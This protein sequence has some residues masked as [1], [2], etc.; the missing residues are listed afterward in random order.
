M[1]GTL[2][3]I[4]VVNDK[5][6]LSIYHIYEYYIQVTKKLPEYSVIKIVPIANMREFSTYLGLDFLD[7][8]AISVRP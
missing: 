6:E 4:K 2:I 8:L 3:T 1:H 7:A 5:I